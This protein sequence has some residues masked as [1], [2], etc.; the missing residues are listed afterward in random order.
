MNDADLRRRY[1]QLLAQRAENGSPNRRAC[2]S[3]SELLDLVERRGDENDRLRRLDHVMACPACHRDF[4]LLRAVNVAGKRA[5]PSIRV[6]GVP[7]A[8]A[9]GIVLAV[10]LGAALVLRG[11]GRAAPDAFRGADSGRVGVVAPIGEVSSKGPVVL[12]WRGVPGARG[13][14]VELL[15]TDGRA[16][17]TTATADTSL[18]L[19][20]S[21][22]LSPGAAYSWWVRARLRG[23]EEVRSPMTPLRVRATP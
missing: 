3:P 15:D 16:V 13:Y 23:G 18:I 22:G 11:P 5:A 8:L 7:V 19:P 17:Y 9:A 2:P 21:V 20:P 1:D 4:E 6:L 14:D 10:G 12:Q